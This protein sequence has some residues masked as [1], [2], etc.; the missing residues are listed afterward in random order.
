MGSKIMSIIRPVESEQHRPAKPQPSSRRLTKEEWNAAVALWES[1]HY[2]LSEIAGRYG[3]RP[4]GLQRRFKANGIK[5]GKQVVSVAV[6]DGAGGDVLRRRIEETKSHH[7]TYA[8]ALAQLTMSEIAK[9][10][11]NGHRFATIARAID[12]L[13]KAAKTL[14]ILRKERYALLDLERGG[15]GDDE[16]PEFRVAEFTAEKIEEICRLAERRVDFDDLD[17]DG[18]LAGV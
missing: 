9:C 13:Y 12:V 17:D 14:A 2:S 10:H 7:Y 11:Q 3:I 18:S 4:D 8:A 1:G 6:G 5:K 16:L 15:T